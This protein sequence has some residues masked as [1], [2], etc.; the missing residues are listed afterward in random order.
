M[1]LRVCIVEDDVD[2]RDTLRWFFEEAEAII[3]EAPDGEAALPP[4]SEQAV[5]RVLLLD[6]LM[7]RLDGVGFLRALAQAPDLRQRTAVVLMTARQEPLDAALAELLTSLGIATLF[8]PFDLDVVS[9]HV[10]RAWQQLI[11]ESSG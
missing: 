8:K 5:H 4:L 1:I 7:P 11:Q 3:E 6:R 9:Q 10:E 2:I